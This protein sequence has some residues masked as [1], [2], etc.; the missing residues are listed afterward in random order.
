[1]E[2]TINFEDAKKPVVT[3]GVYTLNCMH[4]GEVI[5]V[6]LYGNETITTGCPECGCSH[7]MHILDFC[8]MAAED[9]EFYGTSVLCRECSTKRA[10][11]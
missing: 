8:R 5:A 1:M 4:N 6:E 2:K 10:G 9:F 11:K 7:Q 3:S